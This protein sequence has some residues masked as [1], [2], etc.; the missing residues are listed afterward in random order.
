[1]SHTFKLSNTVIRLTNHSRSNWNLEMLIVGHGGRKTGE[2]E[3]KPSEYGRDCSPRTNHK[4][5]R[6]FFPFSCACAYICVSVRCNKCKR[7][8]AQKAHE[9]KDIYHTDTWLFF[10]NE[11]TAHNLNSFLNWRKVRLLL[12][13]GNLVVSTKLKM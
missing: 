13:L 2:P 9:H 1:M 12:F 11:N 4:H 10:A 7:N 6:I 8:T 5:K 3:E